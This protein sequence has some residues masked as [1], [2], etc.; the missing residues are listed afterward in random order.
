M[1]GEGVSAVI[2][3][4][5]SVLVEPASGSRVLT[6]ELSGPPTPEGCCT[7][8]CTNIAGEVLTRIECEQGRDG[9]WLRRAIAQQLGERARCLQLVQPNASTVEMTAPVALLSC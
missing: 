2:L 4:I 7:V 9:R 1:G 8:V 3:D 5:V 6:C